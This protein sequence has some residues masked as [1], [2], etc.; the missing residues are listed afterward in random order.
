MQLINNWRTTSNYTGEQLV[1]MMEMFLIPYNCGRFV[2]NAILTM[3]IYS[4]IWMLDYEIMKTNKNQKFLMQHASI[5][6]IKVFS[7]QN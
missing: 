7:L 5:Y 6:L 4:R 3:L 1:S 2:I